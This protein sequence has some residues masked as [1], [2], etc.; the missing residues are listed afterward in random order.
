MSLSPAYAQ[1]LRILHSFAG[2]GDGADV[3]GGVIAYSGTLYGTT[4]FGGETGANCPLP[5]T[6]SSCGT[7]FAVNATTGAETVLAAFPATGNAHNPYGPPSYYKGAL[8]GAAGLSIYKYTLASKSFAIVGTIDGYDIGG[9]TAVDKVFYGT[10]DDGGTDQCGDIFSFTPANNKTKILY[11]FTGCLGSSKD[12]NNPT[13]TPIYQNGTLYGTTNYGGAYSSGTIYK[14]IVA[15]RTETILHDFGSSSDGSVPFGSL[16]YVSGKL[17]GT[18]QH[19]G[20][21]NAGT[22]FSVDANTGAEAVLYSFTNGSDGGNPLTGLTYQSGLLYGTDSSA[23]FSINP[24]TGAETT[25]KTLPGPSPWGKLFYFKR[26]FLG[27]TEQGGP[28]G[29]GTVFKFVP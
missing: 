26:S 19:G 5:D 21:N 12:G 6:Y 13:A 14:Y 3:R 2:G 11:S 18:T 16:I 4:Y 7:L 28:G 17:Y 8:Y 10:T 1:A 15:T 25:F 9:I 20:V 29:Y 27:T 22:V 23:V 24:S